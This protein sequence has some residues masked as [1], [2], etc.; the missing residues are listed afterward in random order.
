M[1][2]RQSLNAINFL[3]AGC[4][5]KSGITSNNLLFGDNQRW[6]PSNHVFV[7][8]AA[9]QEEVL[10]DTGGSHCRGNVSADVDER[11]ECKI[12]Y[13]GVV[14]APCFPMVLGLCAAVLKA[15]RARLNDAAAAA[16][17]LH[18]GR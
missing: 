14:L 16:E 9:Q 11:T 12:P 8:S 13:L 17:G 2:C 10:F 3:Q 1:K 18:L 5:H 4:L 6:D 15:R 7:S